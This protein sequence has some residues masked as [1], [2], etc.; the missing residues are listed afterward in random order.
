[1]NYSQNNNDVVNP[2][3]NINQIVSEGGPNAKQI[4]KFIKQDNEVIG[5]V[6]S[7]GEKVTVKEAIQLAKQGEL[8]HVGVST[9]KA[10]NE[11]IRSLPDGDESNN[12]DNLPSI[13]EM[14]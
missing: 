4:V 3:K 12:L 1:M 9:S 14:E 5:Y 8:E 7:N 11:Y 6:L 10:G 2:L 13:T